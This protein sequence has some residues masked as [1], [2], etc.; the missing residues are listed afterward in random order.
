MKKWVHESEDWRTDTDDPM[1][2]AFREIMAENIDK[3]DDSEVG[4]FWYDSRKQELFGVK[5]ANVNDVEF[6]ESNLFDEPVKT[7]TPLHNAVW[8]KEQHRNKDKRFQCDY[9]LV[10]RGRVF[11]VKDEGFVVVV[12]SWIDKYPEAKDEILFEFN[13]PEDTIFKKDKHWDIGHGWSD[14]FR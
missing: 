14:K 7:C 9:T 6:Y 1:I 4:I 8:K 11:Y 10:P 12:G 13:L 5:S 3:Q 2:N